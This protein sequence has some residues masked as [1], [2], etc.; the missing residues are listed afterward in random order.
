MTNT[1]IKDSINTL[2]NEI[3][4]LQGGEQMNKTYLECRANYSEVSSHKSTL[5]FHMTAKK[6]NLKPQI[7]PGFS[8]FFGGGYLFV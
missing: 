7:F 3:S 2:W 4:F 8:G 6:F 5:M 1:K